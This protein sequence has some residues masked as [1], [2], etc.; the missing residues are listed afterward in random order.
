MNL[1][2]LIDLFRAKTDDREVPYLW[3]DDEIVEYAN[4]AVEEAARRAGLLVDSTSAVTEIDLPAGESVVTLDPSVIFV[5]RATLKSTGRP[6][7]PRVSRTMDELCPNWEVRMPSDPEIFVPDW[8]T[9]KLFIVPPA[10]ITDTLKLT[11]VRTPV[12]EMEA[13]DDEP[14]INRRYHRGLLNGMLHHGYL[15]PDADTFNAKAA[16]DHEAL[17]TIEFG[18][19]SSAI[20]EHWAL[21]QYYGI[22]ER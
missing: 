14:E 10:A 17:F 3:S 9:G 19:V 6:L 4:A 20:D 7:L 13:D 2:Q 15:K 1:R 18:P 22:G 12:R 21:E 16:A 11:V 8:E 5:R